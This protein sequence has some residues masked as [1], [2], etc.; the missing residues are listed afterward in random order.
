MTTPSNDQFDITLNFADLSETIVTQWQ[1]P[2][3]GQVVP[4][5]LGSPGCAK[6][7]LAFHI[8]KLLGRTA[9]ALN[10]STLDVPDVNGLPN[11][12]GEF[13]VWT[14]PKELYGLT[15][16]SVLILEEVADSMGNM[17]N[18]ACQIMYD[19]HIGGIDI[20]AGCL[21]IATGNRT[22]DKSG[23]KALH[24][25]LRG[26]AR[27]YNMEADLEHWIADYA[28]PNNVP[29]EV[30]QFLRFKPALFSAFD[31]MQLKSPT[32]RD[33]ARVALTPFDKLKENQLFA[34]V[35]GDVG[36]EAAAEFIGFL[37]FFK[38]IP[39]I[40]SIVADPKGAD[41]PRELG[42]QYALLGKLAQVTMDTHK[43]DATK[44]ERAF[45][46]FAQYLVQN[47]RRDQQV[48]YFSDVTKQC[49]ALQTTKTFTDF[50]G[51]REVV[52]IFLAA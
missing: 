45:D 22:Q 26:R 8:A 37:K 51:D 5:I 25:K 39:D 27:M 36:A 50:C 18:A 38:Q 11:H 20:P 15:D 17:Q 10:V 13:V 43:Q 7:A 52:D 21:I 47:A 16:N 23:A 46:A 28:Q 40:R 9:H 30:M 34:T 35:T 29:V 12:K 1:A 31:P 33:W 3:G 41:W 42:V 2:N 49:P 4:I 6:T 19:R 32:P 48:S 24:S 44:G 14:P